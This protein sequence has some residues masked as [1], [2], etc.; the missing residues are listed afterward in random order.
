[1]KKILQKI[2]YSIGYWIGKW[3]KSS[4]SKEIGYLNDQNN[5]HPIKIWNLDERKKSYEYLKKY[6][7]KS[8]LFE[9][10]EKIQNFSVNKACENLSN[11][12]FFF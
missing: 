10:K 11:E 8:M 1:M 2:L 4:F 7:D 12:N 3:L 6:F 5:F 9:S